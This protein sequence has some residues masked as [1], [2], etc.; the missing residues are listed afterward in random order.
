MVVQQWNCF[1]FKVTV[2]RSNKGRTDTFFRATPLSPDTSSHQISTKHLQ[3]FRNYRAEGKYYAIWGHG[4]WVKGQIDT[5]ILPDTPSS[6]QI[7]TKNLHSFRRCRAEGKFSFKVTESRSKVTSTQFFRAT[8]LCPLI[9]H[10]CKFQKLK[11][12]HG[13]HLGFWRGDLHVLF[14][15]D[16]GASWPNG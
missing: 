8:H 5:N 13:G 14:N 7:S 12:M 15:S 1:G 3:S 2:L 16:R 6:H 4:H 10:P 11:K 9:H